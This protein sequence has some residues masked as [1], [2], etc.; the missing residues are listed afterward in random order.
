MTEK[1]DREASN[2][3]ENENSQ[4]RE[5]STLL[6]RSPID[7]SEVARFA[8]ADAA[9]INSVVAH[10]RQ[11]YTRHRGCGP[12]TREDWLLRSAT[13]LDARK[14]EFLERLVVE[15]G[16]PITKAGRELQTATNVLRAAASACRHVY[17][18]TLP[19]DVPDRLSLAIREPLGVVAGITP[20]NVP[21]I[22][23]VKHSALA[24]ATGNAVILMPSPLAPSIAALLATVYADAGVPAGLFHVI[25][26]DGQKIG[27][28]LTAHPDVQA[29]GF[30]GSTKTGRRI[31]TIAAARGAQAT[32]E[33][34]GKNPAVV[35][36]DA[37][38]ATVVPAIT[39]GA[40]LFQ[41]Q[42][43]MSTSRC[44]VATELFDA[45]VPRL[46]AA[47]QRLPSGDLRDPATVVGPMISQQ[48]QS[49]VLAEIRDAID[50]GAQLL[51]GGEACGQGIQPTILMGIR[52]EMAIA[53]H[54]VFGPVL[55]IERFTS[56]QQAISLANQGP[57]GLT[58][59]IFTASQATA[60]QFAR[61]STAAMVHV[62]GP[63]IAE[64]A[65]VPFGGNGD[66]GFG[67]E[68]ALVG[69]E[70]LTRW[71]WLTLG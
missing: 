67:R 38:L 49:R 63:T 22:K 71:K 21:L 39:M 52:P 17:G 1:D 57:Y 41:G 55:C 11:A 44:L 40:F 61:Q 34:G 62:N 31:A 16:S 12:S 27:D 54:E 36:H 43:C 66:S 13:L 4:S 60:M 9:T 23:A 5:S 25:F 58:A 15:T 50:A 29:I 64:E 19:S 10:A 56:L 14:A 8:S 53:Q 65:H 33:M 70:Q 46:V 37:D 45:L 47:A 42:I 6:V 2:S 69:I 26:G 51:T 32:L 48:A 30:T 7:G 24:L 20:F 35:M 18:Q 28:H 68:G 59:S 3:G